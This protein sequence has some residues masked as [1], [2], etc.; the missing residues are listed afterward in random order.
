MVTGS[1]NDELT[2]VV[3]ID[4]SDYKIGVHGKLFRRSGSDWV[5]SMREIERELRR[6]AIKRDKDLEYQR[7]RQR[8][9]ALRE[10]ARVN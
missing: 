4:G 2:G 9:A 5:L 3:H 7:Q 1:E 6:V 8:K 10:R